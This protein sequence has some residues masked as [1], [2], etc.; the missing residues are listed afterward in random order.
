MSVQNYYLPESLGE[1]LELLARYGPDLLV[2]AG[3]TVAMPLINEG[4]STPVQVM[5]LRRT[6]LDEMARSNGNVKIGATTT[7]T[8]LLEESPV[9]LLRTAA[10]NTAAWTI[11]NMGTV[12]GNLFSPPPAGDVAVALLAL[13]AE[14]TLTGSGGERVVPLA[15]FWTGFMTNVMQ[16]DELVTAITL[17]VPTGKTA[18]I[19]YGR[20]QAHTPA[21]VT[22]AAH[23]VVEGGRVQ[24]ARLA[25]G[26][27]GP[28]PLRCPQ[29]EAVLTGSELSED[30]IT[31]AA[32][33][34][35]G[36]CDPFTDAIASEWYRRKMVPVYVAR[37]LRQIAQEE[38]A[39]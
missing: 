5:G 32:Q 28:H 6:G 3:G 16:A 22:V 21:V 34:A 38:A 2:I 9:P 12:G 36:E 7:L 1:A 20:K 11:R 33:T 39:S 14:V 4:V 19:K 31:E 37:A 18:Y 10:R 17:P 35:A 8:R 13:D 26:A 29:A 25:L 24:Q 30:A 15:R 27:V 23:L